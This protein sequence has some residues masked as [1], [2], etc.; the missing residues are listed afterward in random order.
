VAPRLGHREQR[1]DGSGKTPDQWGFERSYA[2]L[3]GAAVNHF[4]HEP[5]ARRTTPKTAC[6]CSRGS[7]AS[8]AARVA[9]R[10]QFYS[11]DFFTDKLISYIDSNRDGKPFFAYAAYTS[12]HW[13]LQVPEPWLSKYKGRY[14]AG[15]APSARS[16]S[17]GSRRWA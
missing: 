5:R 8:R 11:T 12:P 9:A 13:P 16:A 4:A 1:L 3:G 2:L 14:D 10:P 17:R 6:T 15:Y 7:R